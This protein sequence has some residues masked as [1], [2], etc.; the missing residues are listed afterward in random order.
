MRVYYVY[1]INSQWFME[2]TYYGAFHFVVVVV[3]I[4]IFISV[5]VIFIFISASRIKMI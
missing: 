1:G 5:V 4:F 3:V 2:S